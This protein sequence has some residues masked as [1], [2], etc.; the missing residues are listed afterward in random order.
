MPV[1][2]MIDTLSKRAPSIVVFTLCAAL[3]GAWIGVPVWLPTA[4]AVVV[5]SLALLLF[6]ARVRRHEPEAAQD[7]D[8]PQNWIQYEL[9][10]NGT[11]P[12]Y[13]MLA[14]FGFVTI[15]LTGFQSAYATPAW[16]GLALGIVWGLANRTYPA[17]GEIER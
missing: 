11:P 4:L 16:A 8:A 12:G 9:A 5:G 1:S 6:A 13:Y 17:E 3:L 15:M 2:D 10:N 7:E 14:F